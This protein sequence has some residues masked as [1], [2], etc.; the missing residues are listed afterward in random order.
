MSD[1][2]GTLGLAAGIM[3]LFGFIPY[4]LAVVR[5]QTHPNCATWWI[6]T[7]VGGLLCVSYYSTGARESI[8]VP[9]SYVFGPLVTALLSLKYGEGGWARLDRVCLSGSVVSVPLWWLSGL[10]IAA[11][12]IN[13]LIDL[14]G[15]LPTI[16]KSW[17]DPSS[18]DRLAW[19][20][21]LTGNTLNLLALS[22]WPLEVSAYPL[23]L[24]FVSLIVSI[25]IIRPLIESFWRAVSHGIA[26]ARGARY[27]ATAP[28][29]PT[30]PRTTLWGLGD[31]ARVF[32]VIRGDEI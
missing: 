16:R 26:S 14:C 10:P 9:V 27:P 17:S 29:A 20:C 11:L 23:Y 12:M 7:V 21:F 1:I 22:E 3:S 30:R 2:H 28:T 24:F 6:W 15:A 8:W 18:E 19:L 32:P 13:I 31:P 5:G 4:I 25:L